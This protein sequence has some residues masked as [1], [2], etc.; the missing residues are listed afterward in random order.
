MTERLMTER[1]Q[2]RREFLVQ[3]SLWSSA[4]LLPGLTACGERSGPARGG[5]EQVGSQAPRIDAHQ[6]FWT[7]SPERYPWMDDAMASLRRDFAPAELQPELERAGVS[8]TVLVE[9]RSAVAETESLLDIAGRTDFV[10]GVVGWLPLSEPGVG[11]LIERFAAQPKFRGVRHAILAEPDPEFMLRED[12]NRGV[13]QLTSRRLTYDLLLL[14]HNL[15]LAPRFVDRHPDQLFVLDHFAKPLIRERQL[16]PWRTELRELARR[17]NVY[18]KLSGLVTEAEHQ[19]WQPSDLTPYW[20]VALEAFT[21]SRLL[22]GSDWPVCTLAA[23]Y[24]RWLETVE[25]WLGALGASERQRVLG[26]TAL[27]VYRL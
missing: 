27:E 11:E 19:S 18:C 24:Q 4:L 12:F 9:A 2:G 16:E 15:A 25:G 5:P 17:P 23:S 8:G 1:G 14:P 10:R 20:D 13:A 7:Y 21:P 3:S 22:F 6:H 26:G